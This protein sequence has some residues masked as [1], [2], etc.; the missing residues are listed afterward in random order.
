[1]RY[2]QSLTRHLFSNIV[3]VAS[4][5]NTRDVKSAFNNHL[6]PY[7]PKLTALLSLDYLDPSG[8]KVRLKFRRN[9]S[10]FQD[11]SANP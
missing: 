8:N 5:T 1:M 3:L 2:E 6:A 7:Q 9:G 10:F 4:S 11:T